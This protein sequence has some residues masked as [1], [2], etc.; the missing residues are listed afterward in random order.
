M[1]LASVTF[2][3][4]AKPVNQNSPVAKSSVEQPQ[5]KESINS[6]VCVGVG[7]A[8]LAA[9]GVYIATGRTQNVGKV[10]EK[11]KNAESIMTVLQD[12]K[13]SKGKFKELLFKITG[14]EEVAER[15]ITEV[16]ANPR[17]SKEHA[18]LLK[19]KIGGADELLDW[20]IQP[21]GYQEAYYRHSHKVYNNAT[22]PDDLIGISPNW[23]IWVMKDKFGKDFS[24]GDLPKEIGTAD[25]YREIF[26]TGLRNEHAGI[27]DGVAFGD[28]IYGGLSGKAVRPMEIGGKK[29]ILKFQNPTYGEDLADNIDMKSDSAF[30]NAQLERY[31]GL[32]DYQQGP[33]LKF[34]DYKTHSALYEMSE[35]VRPSADGIHDIVGINKKLGELNDLGVYYNDL[36]TSNFLVDNGRLT[37]IDSGESSFVD[38][39]KPGVTALHFT[40]P[41]LNGRSITES[42]AAATLA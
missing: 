33:K 22:K 16:T 15:F 37:F 8:C 17:K 13:L 28:Y 42:A 41:N 23:N 38:F 35:G 2:S 32:H 21:K 18:S 39:F 14:E 36:N 3:N 24:F 12:T 40:S 4:F 1:S 11:V 31:L 20:M 10:F 30:L 5:K 6:K 7:L 9:G 29:Y 34:Y 25:R 19:K 27:H 26:E